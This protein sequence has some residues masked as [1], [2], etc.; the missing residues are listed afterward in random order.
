MVWSEEESRVVEFQRLW[1]EPLWVDPETDEGK[2]VLERTAEL[3]WK[4]LQFT[5]DTRLT[6]VAKEGTQRQSTYTEARYPKLTPKTLRAF[7]SYAI[8]NG[9][10][11]HHVELGDVTDELPDLDIKMFVRPLPNDPILSE[12]P[13]PG[14]VP[15]YKLEKAIPGLHQSPRIWYEKLDEVLG[16]NAWLSSEEAPST[17]TC[18]RYDENTLPVVADGDHL[19]AAEKDEGQ[20]ERFKGVLDYAFDNEDVGPPTRLLD[21]NIA[22]DDDEIHLSDEIKVASLVKQYNINCDEGPTVDEPIPANFDWSQLRNKAELLAEMSAEEIAEGKQWV[23]S[24]LA[25]LK[26]LANSTRFDLNEVVAR[27]EAYQEYP[28][29]RIQKLVQQVLL[30]VAQHPENGIDM[31]SKQEDKKTITCNVSTTQNPSGK[32]VSFVVSTT[33]NIEWG[34]QI[35]GEYEREI[36]VQVAVLFAGLTEVLH[37][38]KVWHFLEH[39]NDEEVELTDDVAVI[40][41]KQE[42]FDCVWH[43]NYKSSSSELVEKFQFIQEN[44]NQKEWQFATA[45]EQAAFN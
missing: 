13:R 27:L 2:Q 17:F 1:D 40:V 4:Q 28:H 8:G 14:L 45:S 5:N 34:C 24:R 31:G 15:V 32:S 25:S 16:D 22:C 12:Q 43:N 37:L 7:L 19:I 23:Q 18:N 6:I 41:D 35:V 38:R 29:P 10:Q 20:Y 3:A 11:L 39:N 36:D 26:A 21:I 9:Y 33:G 42:L 30:Y 44:L